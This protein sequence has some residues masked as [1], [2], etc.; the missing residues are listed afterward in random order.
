M[1]DDIP[2]L[3][4]RSSTTARFY[5]IEPCGGFYRPIIYAPFAA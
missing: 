3:Q 4:Q 1:V 2:D 5:G